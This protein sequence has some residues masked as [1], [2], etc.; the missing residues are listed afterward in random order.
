MRGFFLFNMVGTLLT[1]KVIFISTKKKVRKT[2]NFKPQTSNSTRAWNVFRER[3]LATGNR[4]LATGN[5]PPTP[6]A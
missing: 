5:L 2:S 1:Y 6:F 3:K 4:K